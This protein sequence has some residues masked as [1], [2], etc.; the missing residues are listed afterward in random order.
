MLQAATEHCGFSMEGDD[1]LKVVEAEPL[2][3]LME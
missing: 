1:V 3:F 2:S